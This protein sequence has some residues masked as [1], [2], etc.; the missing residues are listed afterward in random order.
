MFSYMTYK[1]KIQ[2]LESKPH[3]STPFKSLEDFSLDTQI[4]FTI[5][6][7]LEH[8]LFPRLPKPCHSSSIKGFFL[9]HKENNSSTMC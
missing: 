8:T 5:M 7:S 2:T 1:S 6:I 3:N 4:V 9:I